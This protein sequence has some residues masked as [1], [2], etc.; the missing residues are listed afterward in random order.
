MKREKE[1]VVPLSAAAVALLKSLRRMGK[2]EFVFPAPRGGT[3]S[4]AAMGAIIDSMHEADLKRGGIGYL[5]P[6]RDKIAT[7]HGFRSSF[8]DWAA[9][10]AYFPSEVI[11]HALAHKLKDKA[12]AAYQRGTLLMKR[13]KLMKEWASYC[14]VRRGASG[15]VI[16][17]NRRKARSPFGA[18]GLRRSA[19][20]SRRVHG[21][22]CRTV[23][24][25]S[26]K[27]RS[28]IPI[29]SFRRTT[30]RTISPRHKG[31]PPPHTANAQSGGADV[32]F[33]D[34]RRKGAQR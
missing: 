34:Y 13:A 9:D 22:C 30:S 5:D 33:H 32:A 3:L 1:H 6:S 4:D 21:T 17:L 18:V 29:S 26:R 19:G 31:H 10:V 24:P 16:P 11:E 12:E 7:P 25:Y 8:R 14:S 28:T 20:K 23:I 2:S 27:C 15:K